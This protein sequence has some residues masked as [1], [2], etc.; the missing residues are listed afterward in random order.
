MTEIKTKLALE[1]KFTE[2]STGSSTRSKFASFH[3]RV[4]RHCAVR[5]ALKEQLMWL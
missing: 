3:L 4:A 5:V 1:K 2:I